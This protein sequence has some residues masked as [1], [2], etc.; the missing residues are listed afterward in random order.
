MKGMTLIVK[1]TTQLIA[2]IVFLYGIYVVLHGHLTPGGGFAGGVII[3]GSFILLTLAYGSDFMKLTRE[4]TGTT[5]TENLAI[6]TALLI[7][8]AGLI[9]GSRVFFSNWLPAGRVG[10]LIS[11]GVIPLYNIFIGIEVAASILTIFLA[12]IIFKEE[13]TK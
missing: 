6:F 1:K 12:L 13:I 9:T 3:A 7:A 5:I 2:G 11:A 8:L 4:E 10:E